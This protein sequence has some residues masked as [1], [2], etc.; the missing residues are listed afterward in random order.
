MFLTPRQ[1]GLVQILAM[2][3]IDHSAL[4]SCALITDRD[5]CINLHYIIA[6]VQLFHRE[7]GYTIIEN[8]GLI[9]CNGLCY[10]LELL[11]EKA[12]AT[13]IQP[14]A[15]MNIQSAVEK[16]NVLFALGKDVP[17]GR[18]DWLCNLRLCYL[19]RDEYPDHDRVRAALAIEMPEWEVPKVAVMP[20]QYALQQVGL[21]PS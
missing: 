13:I 7:L 15:D 16:F 3:Q 8:S 14:L 20:I 1:K 9:V 2:L 10:D 5:E 21:L 11:C 17:I 6:L 18:I 12:D 19:I 4:I